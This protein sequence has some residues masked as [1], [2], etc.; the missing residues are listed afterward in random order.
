M[1]LT[2]PSGDLETTL[3][4]P[5]HE[6]PGLAYQH[7]FLLKRSPF[8]STLVFW[9]GVTG[10]NDRQRGGMRWEHGKRNVMRCSISLSDS[11]CW[12][13][14]TERAFAVYRMA[15]QGRFRSH[16]GKR[17][18]RFGICAI[19]RGMLRHGS[20]TTD[21]WQPMGRTALEQDPAVVLRSFRNAASGRKAPPGAPSVR[22][23]MHVLIHG[24]DMCRPL[25]IQRRSPRSTSRSCGG[26][27]QAGRSYIRRQET[28][29]GIEAHGHRYG[30]V[31]WE[32]TRG[33][34]SSGGVGDDDGWALGRS[35]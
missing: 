3:S 35:R 20:T 26:L 34:R 11:P 21:G 16:D 28:H 4:G 29:R 2:A 30:M 13:T 31:S 19:I 17:G 32:R 7:R 5:D 18:R 12:I 15:H 24:Q 10:R 27:C 22:G 8:G 23:L 9:G 1:L 25:G 6:A 14:N 33:N